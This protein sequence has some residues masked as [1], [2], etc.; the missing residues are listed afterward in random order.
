MKED[1]EEAWGSLRGREVEERDEEA[2]EDGNDDEDGDDL[3]KKRS[4]SLFITGRRKGSGDP[5]ATEGEAEGGGSPP[6]CSYTSSA[7]L[8]SPYHDY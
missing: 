3:L 8:S 6:C 2:A 5:L 4:P 7:M 1:E